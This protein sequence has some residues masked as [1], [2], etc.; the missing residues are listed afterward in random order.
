MVIVLARLPPMWPEFKSQRGRHVWVEFVVGSLLRSEGFFSWYSGF[1]LSSE[2]KN[3]M[4]FKFQFDYESG[5]T[6]N[7]SVDV[8][9]PNH[10][11][12]IN[13]IGD[14]LLLKILALM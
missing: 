8:I 10:Y 5:Q 9:P 13:I 2:A 14:E 7:H 4:N 11:L 1:S 3:S 6:K 12:F